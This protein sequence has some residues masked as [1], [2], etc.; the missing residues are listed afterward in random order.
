[1]AVAAKPA[2]MA[3]PVKVFILKCTEKIEGMVRRKER[4]EESEKA[5]LSSFLC[6]CDTLQRN[7]MASSTEKPT[8]DAYDAVDQLNS[9][10]KLV[11]IRRT[12]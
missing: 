2:A 3:N 1:M 11:S 12:V 7:S 9:A 6:P 10:R 8:H 4:R 5:R